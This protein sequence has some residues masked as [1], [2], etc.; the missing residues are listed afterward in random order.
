MPLIQSTLRESLQSLFTNP[1]TGESAKSAAA[2]AWAS[3]M[4][5]YTA[6]VVPPSTTVAAA[7]ATLQTTLLAAFSGEVS[8]IL[9]QMEV[10]FAA[11]AATVGTGMAPAFVA[12]PPVGPVGFA[13]LT[14]QATQAVAAQ[15][16]AN[17]ID[18][19]MKTAIATPPSGS[20]VSWS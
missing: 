11:F 8:G 5:A 18:T 2:A 15:E 16:W 6:P 20:A 1:P 3:A 14:N 9:G 7:A 12:T 10:A 17:K 13:A 4:S 19:W